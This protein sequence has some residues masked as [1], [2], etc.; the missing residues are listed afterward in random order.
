MIPNSLYYIQQK[1]MKVGFVVESI[2]KF[3]TK[4]EVNFKRIQLYEIQHWI[5]DYKEIKL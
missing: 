1:E 2:L 5:L 3:K 4:L